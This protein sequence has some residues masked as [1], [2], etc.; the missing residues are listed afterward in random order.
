MP[1]KLRSGQTQGVSTEHLVVGNENLDQNFLY[2]VRKKKFPENPDFFPEKREREKNVRENQR[3]E[4]QPKFFI[5]F[6]GMLHHS[7]SFGSYI[8]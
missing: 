4:G 7:V 1:I 2:V 8:R 5:Y 3:R 6:N